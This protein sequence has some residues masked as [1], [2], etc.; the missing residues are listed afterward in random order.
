M[1]AYAI[2]GILFF[3]Q[4]CLV[5]TEAPE[6]KA[7]YQRRESK[8]MA[9]ISDLYVTDGQ[10]SEAVQFLGQ[11]V[12]IPSV[13]NPHSPDYSMEQLTIAAQ[14]LE[15]KLQGLGFKVACPSVDGSPPFV[16][17]EK[18]T[19]VS[20]PTLLLYAHYDVQPVNREKWISDPFIME[21][22]DGRLYGRG[23]SDDKA[24]IVAIITAL[25]AYSKSGRE[26]PVNV[27]IL[28]EGEEEFGSSHMKPLLEQNAQKLKADA[29]IV[30]DGLNRDV[31][32]GTLTSSTRGLVN[33]KL[34]VNALEKPVHS[35]I[36]CLAPDPAQAL[37]SLIYSLR[38]PRMIP[39]FMDNSLFLNDHER[40]ILA[41]GSQ[42]AESYA[43]AMGVLK[44]VCLRGDPHE[45]IYERI[46]QEPSISVVNM[47]CGQPNGGNS[48]QDSA[49]CTIGIRLIP[50]QV[51]NQVAESVIKYLQS[52]AI[53]YEL[54]IEVSRLEK[55][56]WAWKANLSGHF[57]KKYL[58]ALGE[59]FPDTS[60]MPCG[61]ALPL[62]RE[63]QEIFPSMEMIVPGVEDPITAAHSH[64]ES[65]DIKLFRNSINTLISF[66]DKAGK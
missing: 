38:D 11:L 19:D 59:N 52:Q 60:A 62:L 36:G 48:I 57:S 23:A 13:S 6:N 64:N 46:V 55:G 41:K 31:Q 16:I 1:R 44:E 29:L 47:T 56:A 27:K 66:F 20:K 12:A 54:P 4:T 8:T 22:R 45:S 37:A 49:S 53:M 61:G 43:R 7:L 32:T 2:C 63:F 65:Q 28:F 30:L 51:P 50:G 39:G 26:L 24:G 3:S 14:I 34:K 9:S 40:E 33:L 21:E 10:F 17:A 15:W 25:E 5:A 42:S 35:G 18:T 58:E